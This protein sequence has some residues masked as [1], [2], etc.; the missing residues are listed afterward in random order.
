M[1]S[2]A[3]N[4]LAWLPPGVLFPQMAARTAAIKR[5][6]KA[7]KAAKKAAKKAARSGDDSQQDLEMSEPSE[8]TK[9]GF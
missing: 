5:E 4:L 7:S 9:P 6:K 3:V 1:V 8:E 2:I